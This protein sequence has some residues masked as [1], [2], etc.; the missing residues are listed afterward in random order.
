[1]VEH[2]SL[3]HMKRQA[4]ALEGLNE[5]FKHGGGDFINRG[6]N[7]RWRDVLSPDEIAKCDAI[8]AK[9]LT[10]D[11]ARWLATGIRSD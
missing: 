10:P 7:G 9:R 5:R 2:C 3:E 1:M 8:A 4:A 11:C 6:T